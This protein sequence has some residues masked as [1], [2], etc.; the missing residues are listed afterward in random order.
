MQTT[1]RIP[2]LLDLCCGLGGWSIGFHRAG[3]K[4]LGVDVLDLGYPYDLILADVCAWQYQG[5]IDVVTASPPCTE[6]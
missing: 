4:C 1:K 5:K 2:K 3:F 6:W